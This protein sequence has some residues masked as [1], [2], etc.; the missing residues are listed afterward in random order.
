[1]AV[2]PLS[3]IV[4]APLLPMK[5]DFTVDWANLKAYMAWIAE[6]KP[7]AIAL[8]MDSTEVVPLRRDEQI[9]V[10]RVCREVVGDAGPVISG[11]FAGSTEEAIAFGLNL[12]HIGAQAL[13]VFPPFPT[14]L[15]L[16]L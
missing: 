15:G 13:V 16:P 1:M 6:Q 9:E 12:K 2:Q 7:C 10:T 14:F 11:L 3:G 5:P 8:N 4:A